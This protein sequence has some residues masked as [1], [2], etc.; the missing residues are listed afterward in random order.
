MLKDHYRILGVIQ[1]A[2]DIV[3]KAAY[4][5]LAQ[6][7]HPDKWAGSQEEATMRMSE[8]NKAFSVLSDQIKRR[9]YDINLSSNEYNEPEEDFSNTVDENDLGTSLD[10]NW[11]TV[12]KYFPDLEDIFNDLSKI[13]RPLAQTYKVYL[14]EKKEFTKRK[15]IAD[16]LEREFL[17]KY[18]GTNEEIIKFS[19]FLM[20]W[21]VKNAAK[22]L[23]QVINLMGNDIQSK[24]IINKILE[25]YPN[26]VK[27]YYL[28]QK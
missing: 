4:R 12:V 11:S 9:Q 23:N 26:L 25:D 13:S 2:E 6:R 18:F 24:S 14:L 16:K 3:I 20:G 22:E 8:I 28:S 5:A 7:Y 1:D 10:Y 27:P 17:E 15:V 19:K 21:G